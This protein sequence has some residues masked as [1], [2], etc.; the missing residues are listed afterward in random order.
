MICGYVDILL[1]YEVNIIQESDRTLEC[2]TYLYT[3]ILK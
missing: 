1:S 3:T 2:L